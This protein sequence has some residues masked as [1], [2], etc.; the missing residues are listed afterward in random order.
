MSAPGRLAWGDGRH[1]ATALIAAN[2][3]SGIG[4]H[5]AMI[6]LPLYVYSTTESTVR[7]GLVAVVQL[8]PFVL[9]SFVGGA[10]IDRF[11]AKRVSVLS[12]VTSGLAIAAIPLI[13][14]VTRLTLWQILALAFAGSLLDGPGIS[15][16]F[17]LLP[18]AIERS[19]LGADRMNAAI[20]ATDG[21]ARIGGPIL[22]GVLFAAVGAQNVLLIDAASFAVSA[23]LINTAVVSTAVPAPGGA[24]LSDLAA[25]LRFLRREAILLRLIVITA[26]VN[27][28]SVP[29]AAVIVPKLSLED[30]GSARVSGLL[31]G[32][33]GLGVILGSLLFGVLA[34]RR[35]R[36]LW[37]GTLGLMA[38]PFA[39]LAAIPPVIVAMAGMLCL[40]VGF[41]ML[42]GLSLGVLQERTPEEMRGRVFG[43]RGAIIGSAAPLSVVAIGAVLEVLSTP[44]VLLGLA[45]INV[46]LLAWWLTDPVFRATVEP[47][48]PTPRQ[49]SPVETGTS[50]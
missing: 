41:G 39:T 13:D 28:T 26:V 43:L 50:S 17:S 2:L 37:V 16:R 19:T 46:G 35:R 47:A 24:L 5:L 49:E 3:I 25:G 10:I 42:G 33:D 45:A 29:L 4:N 12:D 31:V 6:V 22:G 34:Q 23:L 48:T 14:A 7:T 9:A 11:G 8:I 1:S 20:T 36:L 38:V 18:D 21:I 40:G 44:A 30:Y 27:I 15:A 32:A